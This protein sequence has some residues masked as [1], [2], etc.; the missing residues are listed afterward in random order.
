MLFYQHFRNL[1]TA[2]N[3]IETGGK[4]RPAG[5]DEGA[6][7]RKPGGGGNGFG[8]RSAFDGG[9]YRLDGGCLEDVAAR[10][11]RE[12]GALKHTVNGLRGG[13]EEGEFARL[14]LVIDACGKLVAVGIISRVRVGLLCRKVYRRAV[15]GYFHGLLR[16]IG[17]VFYIAGGE[18]CEGK[19]VACK[20]SRAYFIV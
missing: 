2:F 16:R 20:V 19:L 11:F 7:R 4:I 18:G 3:D 8:S 14:G 17:K 5:A 12:T 10:K 6:V 13:L 9:A 1:P 15:E